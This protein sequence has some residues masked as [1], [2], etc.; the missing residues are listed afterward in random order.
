[1]VNPFTSSAIPFA[2]IIVCYTCLLAILP[3][4]IKSS[5]LLF[6]LDLLQLIKNNIIEHLDIRSTHA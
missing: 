3:D 2:Q 4:P 6:F 5:L 1:M